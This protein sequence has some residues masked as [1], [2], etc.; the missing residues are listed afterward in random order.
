MSEHKVHLVVGTPAYGGQV[1]TLYT[2]SVLKLQHAVAARPDTALTVLMPSG[3]ALI[4]RSRQDL[5][6]RF[7]AMGDAT[8]LLFVDSD[9]G[10]EPAQV[11][12]LLG[13][14]VPVA[15]GVYPTKKVDWEKVAQQAREGR[16]NLSSSALSYVM[17]FQDPKRIENKDGFA[18]VRY[19]G[20]GFLMLKREALLKMVEKYADLKY[21]RVNLDRDPLKNSP[22]RCALF[23]S[24][25]EPETGVFLS[26][27]Y[28]FCKR[29]RDMGGEVWADL[30]SRLT[31]VGPV[32]FEGDASTQF[33]PA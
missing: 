2:A 8:H 20:A 19:A 22:W 3:D 25:I 14:N 28:S 32:A 5:V 10:F 16:E 18:K 27:D 24:L 12:R 13:F 17:E 6:A 9:V 30:T 11:F 31:H 15:A 7:L 4:T 23:N 29:W 33:G 1:T 26:E 21:G